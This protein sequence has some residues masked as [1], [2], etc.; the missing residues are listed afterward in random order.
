MSGPETAAQVD[1]RELY[2]DL[3]K[4]AISHTLY[5]RTD[6]GRALAG[7]NQITR[8]FLRQLDRR[9]LMVLRELDDAESLRDEGR[10]WPLFGQTMIGRKRLDNVQ[11]CVED[12]LERG[13][14]GNLI[15][16]GVWRGGA[17]ILMRAVLK[18]HG[19]TDRTVYVADSFEGL[20][21][22]EDRYPADEGALWHVADRLAISLDEVRGN[23][24][25]Y[26]LLD[27]QVR[28][29][30]GWFK[31][32]LPT[33]PDPEWAVVRLDGDMYGSTMDG[34][35]ALYPNLSPGGYL[36][37]DD[38]LA[39]DV[40]RQAVDDYRAKHGIDDPIEEID[41][42]GVYWQRGS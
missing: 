19:V 13:V 29:L 42:N 23:F 30:K 9:G 20:P 3:L 4:R 28:F 5:T 27:D 11:W 25:R 41:W 1:T 14:P 18:A 32:T 36:I 6:V 8:F 31:D 26:G 35:E 12:V 21:K 24:E 40:C 38:Y 15:E 34:L 39:I 16:T 7:R 17:T 2:L 22:P 10:D 33:I 37:V